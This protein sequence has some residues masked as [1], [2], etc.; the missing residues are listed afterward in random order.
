M[1]FKQVCLLLLVLAIVGLMY[2]S[3]RYYCAEGFEDMI[4]VE[5]PFVNSQSNLYTN[6]K[7]EIM[8]NPGVNNM[9]TALAV[10]D[11]FLPI[12][13][14]DGKLLSDRLMPDPKN[15]Y[16]DYDNKFCRGALQPANLP[17][18]KRGARDGCGWWYVSDPALT[19]TGVLG[20]QTGPVFT[21]GLP[22]GGQ[23]IWDLTRAQELEEIKACKQIT[24]CEVIDTDSI[25]LRCGF[26]PSSGHAV[27]IHTNGTEKY[28][29]NPTGSCG[30]D[31]I[32]DGNKCPSEN[33]YKSV[34]AWDGT[35][36]ENYGYP[37]PDNSIRLYNKSDCDTLNGRWVPNG[38]CLMLQGGSY[39]AACSGLNKPE[40]QATVC[41]PDSSGRLSSACLLLLTRSLGYMDTGAI[42]R[43]IKRSG[44]MNDTDKVAFTQLVNVGISIPKSILKG[45]EVIDKNTAANLYMR[46]KEQI[47]VGIHTR[48]REAAKWCVTGTPNF[49]P[50]DFDTRE[51]GPFPTSCLQQL[52]RVT[53]CQPA[54]SDYPS[55]DTKDKFS[56]M[57]WG[58]ITNNFQTKYNSINNTNDA[59]NQDTNI[60]QCLGINV[61]RVQ[62]PSCLPELPTFYT[63]Y[64]F[65][66]KG[67]PLDIGRYPFSKFIQNITND[68]LSSIRIPNGY[69]VTAYR[70]DIGSA[71]YTYKSNVNDLRTT[72]FDKTI[73]AL[74][75]HK[76]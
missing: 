14:V 31:L 57:T 2:F 7:E 42:R 23:W 6:Y 65:Q 60:K 4:G 45:G 49:N 36:C 76:V 41:T 20:T 55:D 61:A 16:T 35:D 51:K 66:G 22:G 3:V 27:P 33:S 32:L 71:S 50:C 1:V 24:A 17:R 13:T 40:K 30:V 44:Q 72:G 18:H 21:D 38:E 74:V 62:P 48:V 29:Q 58:E 64:N 75:I 43:I 73:S 39:S 19:S 12:N 5:M 15:G 68:S 69:V 10:P 54:G 26:C 25:H 53:G 47:R 52:W 28:L 8:S 11:V 37:S 67:V 70:D 46:I 59:A 34:I 63:S 56:S 9:T